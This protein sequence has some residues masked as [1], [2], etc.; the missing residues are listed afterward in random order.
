[1]SFKVEVKQNGV[2]KQLTIVQSQSEADC[3]KAAKLKQAEDNLFT[4][5]G[6]DVRTS[7]V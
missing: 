7:E 5:S 6:D 2:W 1:M 4:L 3:V